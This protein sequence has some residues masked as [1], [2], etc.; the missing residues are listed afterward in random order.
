MVPPP[1]A[2]LPHPAKEGVVLNPVDIPRLVVEETFDFV[3]LGYAE[4]E[5]STRAFHI[6]KLNRTVVTHQNQKGLDAWRTRVATE[7]QRA[8]EATPW[9]MDGTSAYGIEVAFLFPRPESV[10]WWRRRH[11]TVKPDIDKLV[12]AVNDAL[13]GIAWN[14]DSQVVRCVVDK[15][16]ADNWPGS[17]P[18]AVV[19]LVRYRNVFE[20]P[21]KVNVR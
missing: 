5:G 10:K 12:R 14:D 8:L 17:E 7:A 16:Y 9:T 13:T 11:C 3:V 1:G 19:T 15:D 6:K 21:R 18:G 2:S 4:P 20:R